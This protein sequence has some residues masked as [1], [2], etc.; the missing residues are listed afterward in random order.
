M[1]EKIRVFLIDDHA[2]LRQGLRLIIENTHAMEVVGEAGTGKEALYTLRRL[3]I[4]PDIILLDIHLPDTNGVALA[5]K[6]GALAPKAKIIILTVSDDS[7]DLYAAVQAGVRGYILKESSANEV[8]EAIKRVHRGEAVLP[9]ALTARLLD[10]L[11]RPG[12]TPTELTE[13]EREILRYIARGLSNKEIAAVVGLSENT[14]KTHVRKIL[15][16]LNARSRAEAAAYAVQAGLLR[17][18]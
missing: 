5:H 2:V 11:S 1:T 6:L 13:R 8:V 17:P 16:K 14:V 9:P 15:T 10:E 3:P 4:P 18:K 12:Y 7:R